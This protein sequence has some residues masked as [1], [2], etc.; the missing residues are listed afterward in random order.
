MVGTLKPRW[1]VLFPRQ[2]SHFERDMDQLLERF[3]GNGNGSPAASG[4]PAN[5][6]EEEGKWCVELELPGVK[7]DA[8]DITLEKNVLRVAATRT[9][10]EGERKYWHAERTYGQ[11]ERHFT[12]PETVDP[13]GI[14]AG[15]AD[16]VLHLTLIKKPEAQP[17]KIE[18][19]L[20]KTA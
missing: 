12:L 15:L 9:A 16:G 11:F 2:L 10:P 1:S 17:K 8:I 14:D 19:K 5:L 6:W 20:V 4:V 18:V 3:A 7:Q 13:E